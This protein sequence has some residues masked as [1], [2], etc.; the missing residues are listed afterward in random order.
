V[1]RV[2]G[3]PGQDMLRTSPQLL[4]GV[5]VSDI[6]RIG[7][8]SQGT[9]AWVLAGY[10]I[11]INGRLFAANDNVG[12]N[13][14]DANDAARLRLT[15]LEA[16]LQPLEVEFA[17]LQSLIELGLATDAD[18]TRLTEIEGALNPLRDEAARLTA[19]LD[20]RMAWYVEPDFRGPGRA[21]PSVQSAAVTLLTADH[22]HAGTDNYVY[23]QTGGHRYLVSSPDAPFADGLGPQR[24]ELDL[25]AGPLTAADLRGYGVG[26]LAAP[27][28]AATAPDRWHPQRIVVEIDGRVVYDSDANALD[29]RSLEAVRVIPPAHVGEDG[30]VVVNTPNLR[31]TTLWEAGRG[32]ALDPDNGGVL[33]LPEES[34]DDYPLAEPDPLDPGF[35]FPADDGFAGGDM[36]PFEPYPG[37]GFPGEGFPGG[38]FPGGFPIDPGFWDPGWGPMDLWFGVFLDWFDEVLPLPDD[39]PALGD[40]YQ[41]DNIQ[42]VGPEHQPADA[43]TVG[44]DVIGDE[45]DIDHY[46]VELFKGKPNQNGTLIG[47]V[48]A[49]DETIVPSGAG[50][51]E[52][53][54]PSGL[55]G[56]LDDDLYLVPVVTAIPS[57]PLA[58]PAD[59]QLGYAKPLLPDIALPIDIFVP[60]PQYNFDN[61]AP[62]S[63]W[64]SPTDGPPAAG[65]AVWPFTKGEDQRATLL[66][67]ADEFGTNVALRPEAGDNSMAVSYVKFPVVGHCKVVAHAGFLGA[68]D[69]AA[70]HYKVEMKR[71]LQRIVPPIPPV[72]VSTSSGVIDVNE[73]DLSVPL[74]YEFDTAALPPG[75]YLLHVQ[76]IINDLSIDPATAAALYGVRLVRQ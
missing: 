48:T 63:A 33:P 2:D 6:E 8:S 12:A 4:T 25:Q 43:F 58:P 21:S 69:V 31:E 70:N 29:R 36:G 3:E 53:T 7:F 1:F 74:S 28:A 14:R 42:F 46:R 44:W 47:D 11:Q 49:T 34:A 26:M 32:I 45:T 40:P 72:N 19:Q 59:R 50:H 17:D 61:G 13:A 15:E 27:H 5:T 52:I 16:E 38:G 67:H 18:R 55:G 73:T 20:G 62:G 35:D 24:M 10:E 65:R 76:F 54:L 22:Q 23:F 30:A 71:T 56:G 41:V 64:L 60:A 57:D 9:Q 39:V 51:Y 75:Q 68:T 66:D 37:E